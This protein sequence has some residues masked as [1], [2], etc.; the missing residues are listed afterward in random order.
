M[1]SRSKEVTAS[2]IEHEVLDH[3]S[4]AELTTPRTGRD[5]D[6]IAKM[7]YHYSLTPNI[8]QMK[9]WNK[10][11]AIVWSINREEVGKRFP[12]NKELHESLQGTVVSE[13]VERGN[14]EIKYKNSR[15]E[16]IEGLMELYIPFRLEP[17][18]DVE[19]VFEVY[20]NLNDLYADI[21]NHKYV[22][23][24]STFS[25]MTVLLLLLTG[26][27]F[28]A[29][30]NIE[31]HQVELRQS[32][33][34]WEETFNTIRD[35]ITI[36]DKDFNI[37]RANKG[38]EAL[39]G[40]PVHKLT[41]QKCYSLYHGTDR[42]PDWCPGHI[43]LKTGSPSTTEFY[44]PYLD[45]HIEISALPRFGNDK[46]LT[47]FIHIVRD[48]TKRIKSEEE[49]MELRVHLLQSQKMESIGRLAGGIA[50]DF[51]NILTAITGYSELSLKELPANHPVRDKIK[52]IKDSG[53]RA[54]ALTSQLLAFS[55]KQ[56]LEVK[57]MNL[58]IIIDGMADMLRRIIGEDIK[59]ALHTKTSIKNII[60]DKNQI[61]QI[62]LNL[63]VNARDAMPDGGSLIVE[64]SDF[65]IDDAFTKTYSGAQPGAYVLLS[66]S[67]TGMGMTEEVKENIF[68]PFY[69]TKDI[70]KGTGLGLSTVYGIIKQHGGYI[71]VYSEPGKGTTFRVY[72]PVGYPDLKEEPVRVNNNIQKGTESILVVE[73]D[74]TLLNLIVDILQPLGYRILQAANGTEAIE[75]CETFEEKIDL[76]LTDVIM[77]GMNGRMLADK[78]TS[79]R[80]KMKVIYMSGYTDNTIAHHGILEPG[81]VLLQKPLTQSSL[82]N[83]IREVLDK[84]PKAPS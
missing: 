38:A 81:I 47:G 63:S 24:A 7:V 17:Q 55:R 30:K 68:E 83:K 33:E 31:S 14:L 76:L 41:G 6:E 25:G 11:Y 84:E 79:K 18:G 21:T 57:V 52:I 22:I 65:V 19:V 2:F 50:H 56:V 10:D 64:T 29:S 13:I 72:I 8:E 49:Q 1:I 58:N 45:K 15:K 34:E 67:D 70:G 40:L 62:L 3:F 51:N 4:L 61:E 74:P 32:K 23:W 35:A 53:D 71:N 60:G 28:R 73:D 66:V 27:F 26:I 82:A 5:Y 48:I 37:I 9:I 77:P 43:A 80:P 44:E 16:Y 78:L 54:A 42:P 39:L 12:D 75:I 59:L 69:T 20:E 46:Q 36:H